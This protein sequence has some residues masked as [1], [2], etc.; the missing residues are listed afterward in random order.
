MLSNGATELRITGRR[1]AI[2]SLPIVLTALLACVVVQHQALTEARSAVSQFGPAPLETGFVQAMAAHHEQAIALA[3][4]L[5]DEKP[6]A[7][8]PLARSIA[9]AQMLELGELRGWL[10]LWQQPL[11]VLRPSMDWMLLGSRPLAAEYQAYLLACRQ[12]PTGMPG[13]AE[14][15]AVE[16]YRRL[17]GVERD[18]RFVALMLAHHRGALPMARFAATEARV[19]AVRALARQIVIEQAEE[20]ATLEHLQGLL[21]NGA[22]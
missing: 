15:A 9:A 3:Q 4:V 13:L 11:S 2:V 12:S 20:L 7:V 5:Q 16:A 19:P 18:R 22:E 14:P 8:L 21:Q 6:S 17:A 1:I 10:R